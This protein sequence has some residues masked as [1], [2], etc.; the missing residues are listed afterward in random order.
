VSIENNRYVRRFTDPGSRPSNE[1]T[2]PLVEYVRWQVAQLGRWMDEQEA[3]RGG[4]VSAAAELI[5]RNHQP[6]PRRG[7]PGE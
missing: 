4:P 6:R 2:D 1:R 3:E 5:L 7:E